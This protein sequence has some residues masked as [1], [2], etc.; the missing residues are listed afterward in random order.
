VRTAQRRLTYCLPA[1]T[2]SIAAS[3]SLPARVLTT[4][5]SAPKLSASCT[6]SSEDSWVRKIILAL[7]TSFRICRP[8]SIPFN[9]GRPMSSRIR[10]GLSSSAFWTA[11]NPSE[12]SQ[13]T[14]S[15]GFCFSAE[16]MK[17]RKGSKSSTT[18][19]RIGDVVSGPHF[20]RGHIT[21]C[22]D[23]TIL[24]ELVPQ[25]QLIRFL[26]IRFNAFKQILTC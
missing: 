26:L 23:A 16:Q 13:T 15:S 5:P 3:R 24:V 6:T 9:P 2:A 25:A 18:R 11:S 7:G 1:R 12:S 10:S 21:N 4:Y 22:G 20:R 19:I 17:D 8:A 14:S